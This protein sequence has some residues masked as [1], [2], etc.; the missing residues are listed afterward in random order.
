MGIYE[1][2][3]GVSEASKSSGRV[4]NFLRTHENKM[5]QGDKGEYAMGPLAFFLLKT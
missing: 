3:E 2:V 1:K 4:G 5:R